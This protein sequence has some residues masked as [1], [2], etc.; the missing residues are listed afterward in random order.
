[1]K[2][3]KFSGI[4]LS[5]VLFCGLLYATTHQ[6]SQNTTKRI[7]LGLRIGFAVPS[8]IVDV[9]PETLNLRSKGKWIT[10]Y[11]ELPEGYNVS[12]IDI[13]TILLNNTISVDPAP[14]AVGDYDDDG[15]PDLMVK[16]DRQTVID[17]IF[18]NV[19]L[20][21]L[22]EK[23]FM[24]I[25]LT[26]TGKLNDVTPFQGSDTV[27]IILPMPRGLYRIFPI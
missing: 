7:P 10:C 9:K 17:Y 8:A 13:S 12:D 25:T 18:A 1:M 11:I 5:A 15:I 4:F 22:F 23:R 27:K 26:I 6:S 2:I 14:T 20:T 24:T 3:A 19:D 21:E 16:F